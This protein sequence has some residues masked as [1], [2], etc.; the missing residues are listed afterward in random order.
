VI[1]WGKDKNQQLRR[2]NGYNN[3][4]IASKSFV[5]QRQWQC[6]Q[7]VTACC[8]VLVYMTTYDHFI[9]TQESE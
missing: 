2:I 6:L 5:K 4:L 7:D 1:K 3:A 9:S 8:T